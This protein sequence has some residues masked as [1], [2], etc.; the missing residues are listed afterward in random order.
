MG[1]GETQM[2]DLGYFGNFAPDHELSNRLCPFENESKI[3]PNEHKKI[4]KSAQKMKFK[5]IWISLDP[6]PG[7]GEGGT[8]RWHESTK[9][10][11]RWMSSTVIGITEIGSIAQCQ[12]L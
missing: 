5:G 9:E 10:G 6:V 12:M 1:G 8:V 7:G 3:T 11:C 4:G 2:T